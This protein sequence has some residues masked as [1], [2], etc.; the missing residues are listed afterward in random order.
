MIFF[1]RFNI[2][3][4]AVAV[5]MF[6]SLHISDVYASG[7]GNLYDM[8]ALLRQPHPFAKQAPLHQFLPTTT[9][10]QQPLAQRDQQPSISAL[11]VKDVMS[12]ENT[13][14]TPAFGWISEIRLGVL[15]H[16]ISAGNRTKETGIDANMEVLFVSADWLKY[17][18]APRP[19][20]GFSLNGS[21]N[22]T[23][24][25]YG[26]ITWEW[27]PWKT[28]FIDFSFGAAGHN[29]KHADDAGVVF[30][31]DVNRQRELG[32]SVLFRESLEIGFIV[33]EHHG[34]S[35]IWDHLSNAGLCSQNEGLDNI[36]IR[37]GY[38]F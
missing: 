12:I 11:M 9:G 5:G 3:A 22:N 6:T 24:Y 33:A 7:F 30:P 19:H 34:I 27:Q 25:A 35:A 17:I 37:Y 18:F 20:I 21:T 38:R 31:A 15:K 26:G 14:P 2:V 29:G 36:G 8:S 32:C 16:A 28:M 23:D 4:V 10:A 13:S 1:N